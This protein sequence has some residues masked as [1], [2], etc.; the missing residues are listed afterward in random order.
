MSQ[1]RCACCREEIS[2]GATT[3]VSGLYNPGPRRFL[4][5]EPCWLEEED[6]VDETGT[7]NHPDRVARYAVNQPSGANL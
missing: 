7:N 6:L 4:L 2:D 1:G 5:C 3:G